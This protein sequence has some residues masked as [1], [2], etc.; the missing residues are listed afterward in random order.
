MH[1]LYKNKKGV[2]FSF[3]KV[4]HHVISLLRFMKC[5]ISL[6]CRTHLTVETT[7][8]LYIRTF[9][10]GHFAVLGYASICIPCPFFFG[11]TANVFVTAGSTLPHLANV[12]L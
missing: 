4:E 2:S 3:Y 8:H 7:Q 1:V 12:I 11:H 9:T 10:G 6:A 5:Q